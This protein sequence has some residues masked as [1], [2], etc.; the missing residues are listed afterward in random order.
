MLLFINGIATR[1]L[2]FSSVEIP[3]AYIAA[4]DALVPEQ[5]DLSEFGR[6][7]GSSINGSLKWDGESGTL[8]TPAV[9]FEP[10]QDF[11][12]LLIKDWGLNP[13]LVEIVPGSVHIRAWDSNVGNGEI[14]RLR[15]YRATIRQRQLSRDD[16]DEI[17]Q[18]IKDVR[19]L[20]KAKAKKYVSSADSI[21]ATFV[22]ALSDWQ[23]GKTDG[24]STADLIDRV[25]NC[26]DR[27]IEQLQFLIRS[28]RRPELILLCGLGDLIEQCTGFYANQLHTVDAD[29]RTQMRVVRS[30]IM[31]FVDRLVD[32]FAEIP[33]LLLAVP[34]NHGENRQNGKF[35]TTVKDNDDLAI[36]EQLSEILA[37]NPTRYGNVECENPDKYLNSDDLTVTVVLSGVITTLAHG[38]QFGKSG[39]G[40]AKAESWLAS[41]ALGILPVADCEIF[42]S[43]HVHHFC[44]SEN[45]G[46]TVII[47]PALD[48]GS[49]WYTAKTGRH[50]APGML[51]ML[52]G[53]FD[54]GRPYQA[55][56]IV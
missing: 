30:L 45:T 26:Q 36:F 46:R 43:A 42:L 54:S 28:G 32:E 5:I 37:A 9:D 11:W 3:C 22:I 51:T 8:D 1:F 41:Q 20:R 2:T 44:V 33:L 10:G 48:N 7:S 21:Q 49:K 38:H 35:V 56:E 19:K 24:G 16:Q 27:A 13:D 47:V 39:S 50:S 23:T 6:R 25:I 34:G 53:K 14:Q 52:I 4:T 40:L 29:R 18:L 31:R 55:I 17:D 12:D 15:Y